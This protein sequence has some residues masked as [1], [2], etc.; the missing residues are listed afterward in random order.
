[1]IIHIN[2]RYLPIGISAMYIK[3]N[4][5]TYPYVPRNLRYI[6]VQEDI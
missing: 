2:Y 4:S 5:N 1:M 6:A 3:S